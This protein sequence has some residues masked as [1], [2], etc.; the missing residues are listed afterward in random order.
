V[1]S[2]LHGVERV[3][4][5]AWMRDSGSPDLLAYLAAER[6]YYD[7]RTAHS[8]PLQDRLFSEMSGRTLPADSSVSWSRGGPVYYTRTVVGKEYEQFCMSDRD[9]PATGVAESA[10]ERVLLDLNELAD[11]HDYLALGVCEPSPDGRWL[12]W[13]LDRD[14]DEQFELRLRDLASGQDDAPVGATTYYTCAWSADSR[15]LFYTVA[16]P[17]NRPHQVWRHDIGIGSSLVLEEPDARFELTVEATRDGRL[18]LIRAESRETTEMSW[19]PAADPQPT[20]TVIWPRREG[21][22]YTVDHLAPADDPYALGEFVILTN[23]GAAEFQVVRAPVRAPRPT[24]GAVV[25][26]AEPDTRWESVVVIGRFAVVGGRRDA[27]PFLRVV[28]LD[29]GGQRDV[30]SGRPVGQIALSRNEDPRARAVRVCVE[31]L[32]APPRWYDVDLVTGERQ[33]VKELL[34]PAYDASRYVTERLWVTAPDGERVPVSLARRVETPLDGTAP[35]LLW[36]YGAYESCEWPEFDPALVS[37]LDRGVVYALAHVRGGGERGRRWWEDGHKSTKHHT[38]SDFVAVADALADGIV[39]GTRIVSRGLSAGGLLQGAAMGLAPRR[40][41]GV[42]AEV[43]FVD[44][45]NSMLDQ[46]V[47][48]T[49]IEWDEWGDPSRPEDFAW[50]MAYAPYENPPTG[51]RPPLL[52]TG[53]VNDPRVLVHEPAKWVARLRATAGAEACEPLL[54]RVELGAGAHIGPAGRY[55]HLRYE[56]E[57]Q[58]WV[59]GAMAIQD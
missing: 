44:C 42:V 4:D 36:G 32:V 24:G 21:V 54:F 34:V 8:R 45:V 57:V 31:S 11:G 2:L 19:L 3:D 33:L 1:H 38:F 14:G 51:Y 39:D 50:M 27:Q 17:V 10:A 43:P 41:A 12:A 52:V 35:C 9:L 49:V 5:Y 28:D 40:W 15:T 55:G 16:D 26:A 56:A 18:I 25:V 29:G 47:P 30:E 7:A 48:L 46:T 6:R 23:D 37:L 59:L 58:A 53:S 13:S 20:P 22:E